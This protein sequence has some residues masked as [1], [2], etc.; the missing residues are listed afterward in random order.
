MPRKEYKTITVKEETFHRFF[1][2]RHE[3]KK[4]D[5]KMYNDRFLN[6]LLDIYEKK[7]RS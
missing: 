1:K 5:R 2:L 3:V 4:K 6:V 7:S